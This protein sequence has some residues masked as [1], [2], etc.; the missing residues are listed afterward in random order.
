MK[1]FQ[2]HKIYILQEGEAAMASN[3]VQWTAYT[4]VVGAHHSVYEFTLYEG[5][6]LPRQ[7]W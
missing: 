3:M 4:L 6:A 2:G 5:P 7:V 1:L